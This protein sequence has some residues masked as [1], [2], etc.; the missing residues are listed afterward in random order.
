MVGA[1]FFEE[2]FF[3]GLLLRALVR[4]FGPLGVS[5]RAARNV[6]LAGA[7]V[8]DGLLFG[9]A[10]GELVQL[11]GLAVFGGILAVVSLRTGRQGMNVVA[12]ATFNLFAI[13]AILNSRG[14]VL[15]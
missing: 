9:L 3:R 8:L 13:L 15:H 12:H 14:G 6:G 1:P 5:S 7:V 10:H 2:L 4:L 11:A